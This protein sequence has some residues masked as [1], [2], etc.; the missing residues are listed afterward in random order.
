MTTTA[1]IMAAGQGKRM[2][3]LTVDCPKHLLPVLGRPFLD[4]LLERLRLAGFTELVIITGYHNHAFAPYAGIP[5]VTL[6]EQR[7]WR[8]R[9]GTAAAIES[10]KAVVGDRSFAAI[11]GD[12]L[13]SVND[14]RKMTIDSSAVWIGGYRT[15]AWQGMGVLQLRED[16]VLDRVVEKPTTY[17]GDLINASLYLFTPSIFGVIEQLVPSP[18]GE[19]EITDAINAVAARET[20]NVFTLEDRWLDLTAP[21]D[22]PK[23]EAALRDGRV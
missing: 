18:R 7:A 17:V 14:L 16:G 8:E 1:V 22:I 21:T 12:N 20:V 15:A 6:V 2:K 9:Y 4:H 23:I 11:A 10:V 13:Y 19:Y 5:D 3:D